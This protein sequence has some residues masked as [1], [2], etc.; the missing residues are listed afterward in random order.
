MK[1]YSEDK[2]A[3]VTK[4]KVLELVE[5]ATKT[6]PIGGNPESLAKQWT[7]WLRHHTS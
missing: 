6:G 2:A 1:W 7:D 4:E 3:V 5:K